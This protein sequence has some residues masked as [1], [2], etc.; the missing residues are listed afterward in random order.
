[1]SVSLGQTF[2]LALSTLGQRASASFELV[3]GQSLTV[4]ATTTSTLSGIAMIPAVLRPDNVLPLA[5]FG[6]RTI[7]AQV[8]GT[9]QVYILSTET[10]GFTG[11][12]EFSLN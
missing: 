1:V 10:N 11:V 5:I 9:Y 8:T 12:V 6:S 7:T 3:E 2:S 4:T